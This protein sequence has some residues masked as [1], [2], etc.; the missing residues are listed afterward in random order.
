MNIYSYSIR[1]LNKKNSH[2]E[3]TT[4]TAFENDC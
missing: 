4:A 1:I 3:K 2:E